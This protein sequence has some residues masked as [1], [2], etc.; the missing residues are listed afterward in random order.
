MSEAAGFTPADKVDVRRFCWYPAYGAGDS[1][2]EGWRFFQAYGLLEYRLNNMA[3]AEVAVAQATFLANLR[4]LE[5]AIVAAGTN[6]A[7][8]AAG[9]WTHN[10][11]EIADRA[12]LFDDWR[13]RLCGFL[14]IP[15]GPARGVAGAITI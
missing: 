2:F 9:P 10:Q 7:T 1:G 5:A 6:L 15:P 14:G 13:V 4:S 12:G 8:A 11:A 3:P